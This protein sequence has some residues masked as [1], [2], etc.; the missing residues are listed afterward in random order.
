MSGVTVKERDLN[1][2]GG[3]KFQG[4]RSSV[5][6]YRFA[7]KKFLSSVKEYRFAIKILN[8]F[9]NYCFAIKVPEIN[10]KS[11]FCCKNVL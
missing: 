8:S 6:S 9:K 1:E 4:V 10:Q 7:I 5:E 2:R 11:S 3:T